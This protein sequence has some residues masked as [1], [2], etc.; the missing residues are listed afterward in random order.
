MSPSERRAQQI[1][2]LHAEIGDCRRLLE[3]LEADGSF[4]A[5]DR[6]RS[7]RAVALASAGAIAIAAA[8]IVP[9]ILLSRHGG[10]AS[11][12]PT[13]QPDK[14]PA[15]SASRCPDFKA[16]PPPDVPIGKQG[17]IYRFEDGG[18][19][20]HT[21]FNLYHPRGFSAGPLYSR[22]YELFRKNDPRVR[23]R[24]GWSQTVEDADAH[25][26]FQPSEQALRRSEGFEDLGTTGAVI[27]CQKASRWDYE[28]I[29]H[30]E[31]LRATRY[32]FVVKTNGFHVAYDVLFEAPATTYDRW[33]APFDLVTRSFRVNPG[34]LTG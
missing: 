8:T 3:K 11:A 16:P 17:P 1:A 34:L 21:F 13:H 18:L 31:R 30:G 32:R 24:I 14:M 27:G 28:R 6:Q 12:Q 33:R 10:A 20:G 19:L 29:S 15:G 5:D 25:R 7:N 4:P 26:Y 23:I 9:V 22:H 2:R